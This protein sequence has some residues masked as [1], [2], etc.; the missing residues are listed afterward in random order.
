MAK[1]RIITPVHSLPESFAEGILKEVEHLKKF[2]IEF[3]N[4]FIKHGPSSIE[5]HFDEMLCAP[6][7]VAAAIDA[8]KAGVEAVII[9]CMGDPGLAAA[10]EAVSIPVF[11]PGEAAMHAAAM[12]GHKFSFVTVL[13]SVRP[14]VERNAMTY[15]VSSK[16]AS[17]RVVDVPV[18]DI[19]ENANQ[20]VDKLFDQSLQAVKLEHVDTIILGCT[21]FLGIAEKLEE[22]LKQEGYGVPVINPIPVTA[23][24]A[25]A[26]VNGKISHSARAY[27]APSPDKLIKGFDMPKWNAK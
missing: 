26:F 22:R 9:N 14:L 24:L 21:G 5:N 13:D 23:V 8:E 12:M 2:D 20:L 11:G 4:V 16:M 19:E 7:T 15:G 1:I 27:P 25:A 3:D 17:I 6:Y 10:R 18:L